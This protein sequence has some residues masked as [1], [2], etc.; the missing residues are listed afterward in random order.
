M[1]SLL[2][3]LLAFGDISYLSYCFAAF[4]A[5]Q[6]DEDIDSLLALSVALVSEANQ[7]GDVC[8]MLDSYFEQPLFHSECLARTDMPLGINL[9]QWRDALLCYDCVGTAD[10]TCPLIIEQ[11][12]LYLYRYWFY[13]DRVAHYILNRLHSIDYPDVVSQLNISRHITDQQQ[14]AVELALRRQFTVISGGPGTGK[15]TVVIHILSMLLSQQ[16]DMRIALAAA[17]GKAAARMLESIRLSLESYTINESIRALIPD[18]AST[19]HRLL[20][21]RRQGLRYSHNHK[22]ALDCVVVDEAS[23]V[24]LTLMYRLLDALP[25]KARVILLGDRDQLSAVAAGNVLGDITNQGHSFLP[26]TDNRS[27]AIAGSVALLTQSYRFDQQQGIGKLASLVNAGDDSAVYALLRS[28]DPQLDWHAGAL[29]QPG[30][31]VFDSILANYRRVVTS[32]NVASALQAFEATRVLCAVHAGA[33]G[34]KAINQHIE[35]AMLKQ[36]WIDAD[37]C[38]RGKPILITSNDYELG[39]FNGDIGMLWPDDKHRIQ[40][41]F[42]DG[43]SLRAL[44]VSSLPEYISAWAMT[45]HKSQGSEFDSVTLILPPENQAFAFPRALL[46]TAVTRARQHLTIC[47]SQASLAAACNRVDVRHSGLAT[48]LG[49]Q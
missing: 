45:V 35:E 27:P 47:A 5:E 6:A 37:A 41:Y 3:T 48:K 7:Q 11:N 19:I 15:T 32:N 43:E 23:M 26:A 30:E 39:L 46:Y 4:I 20:G 12:R 22:L 18:E 36:A 14:A 38:F 49:W 25:D 9:D 31:D 42:S 10:D 2:K 33:F 29:E 16:A 28:D 44:A 17:T 1:K 8:V 13:E 40:A 24:D 21:Y 34:D